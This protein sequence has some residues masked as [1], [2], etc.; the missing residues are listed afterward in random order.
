MTTTTTRS[1]AWDKVYSDRRR[2]EEYAFLLRLA[3][4]KWYLDMHAA[5]MQALSF[6]SESPETLLELGAGTGRLSSRILHR[7]PKARLHALDGS[8]AML[9][10]ARQNLRSLAAR[11]TFVQKDFGRRH[12]SSG[13]PKVDA[14]ISTAAIHHLTGAGKRR[15]FR[16]AF[17]LL[18]PG[19]MLVVGD[20][21]WPA[22][23]SLKKRD[24][25]MWATYIHG[26]YRQLTGKDKPVAEILSWIN[27][28]RDAEGDQPSSLEDQLGWMREAGFVHVDCFWKTFGFAVYGG[29]KPRE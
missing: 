6:L 26:R 12:W 19:G 24:D 29:M 17:D 27:E 22:D 16:E 18:R 4:G 8:E 5:A 14:V 10:K 11:V 20:P 2:A 13:L 15:L 9:A 23:S 25:L 3:G 1:Q 21:V 28:T 7:Y